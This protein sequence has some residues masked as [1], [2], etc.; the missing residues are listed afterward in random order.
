MRY[1]IVSD[2]HSNLQAWNAVLIDIHSMGVDRIICLGDVVGYGPDPAAVLTSVHSH[3][4]HLLL[5]NHDAVIGN[6]LDVE[7]FN[8]QACK[9]IEWTKERL[10]DSAVQ[11]FAELPSEAVQALHT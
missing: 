6:R 1:A 2:I 5:G 7:I 10:D 4:H 8:D 11:L 9:I 3:V